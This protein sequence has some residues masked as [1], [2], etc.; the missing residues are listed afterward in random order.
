[1]GDSFTEAA[2]PRAGEAPNPD[3]GSALRDGASIAPASFSATAAG[4]GG[5]ATLPP[6]AASAAVAIR[7][8]RGRR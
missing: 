7:I 4:V 2:S 3:A 6:T 8:P 1:M 5:W